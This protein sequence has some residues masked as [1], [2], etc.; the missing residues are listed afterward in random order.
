[1]AKIAFLL[2]AGVGYV[3]GA[4]AGRRRYDELRSRAQQ[5]WHSQPVQDKVSTAK[6]AARTKAAPAARDA[7]ETAAATAG[8]TVR[9]GADKITGGSQSTT[10]DSLPPVQGSATFPLGEGPD[11]R[12]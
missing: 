12:S 5:V 9:E 1:M 3:L 7:V 4:R 10:P 6:H 11:P 8:A 2:G